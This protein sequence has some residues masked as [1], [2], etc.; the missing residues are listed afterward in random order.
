MAVEDLDRTEGR[1][2]VVYANINSQIEDFSFLVTALF[3]WEELYPA[4][5]PT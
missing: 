4:I 5:C 1:R 3:H 2:Y